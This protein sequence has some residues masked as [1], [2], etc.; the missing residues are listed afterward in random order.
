MFQR[1][2][3]CA[4]VGVAFALCAG[5]AA[6]VS[7]QAHPDPSAVVQ[8]QQEIS[9][10]LAASWLASGDPRTVAW[11]AWVALRDRRTELIPQMI[12][13][14]KTYGI[15]AKPYV[16]TDGHK[17]MLALLDALIQ[18]G[19]QMR[20]RDAER[21]FPEFPIHSLLLLSHSSD[22]ATFSLL[23]I[24][25]HNSEAPV[26]WAA[27]GNLLYQRQS[28]EFVAD[29]W[30]GLTVH[31]SLSVHGKEWGGFPGTGSAGSCGSGIS[32]P[33][34]EIWPEIGTYAATGFGGNGEIVLAA[35]PD[36]VYYDRVV[37]GNYY[38][39][40]FQCGGLATDLDSMR[41]H[42]FAGLLG[43]PPE[44]SS[45]RAHSQSQIL[46]ATDAKYA[47]ELN[48]MVARQE[49]E[50][51]DTAKKLVKRNLLTDSLDV[52][53]APKIE[54]EIIDQ[55]ENSSKSI[56]IPPDLPLNVKAEVVQ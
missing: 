44:D 20:A 26:V 21:L 23:S 25:E 45:I 47:E 43:L 50:L 32:P 39:G 28:P 36:P 9:S 5:A 7:A 48:A 14:T 16:A 17:T 56:F 27:A 10:K 49:A 8:S 3:H 46:W 6:V 37:G 53:H 19:V 34:R 18:L 42:Y 55:R 30:A 4:F 51:E 13:L 15:G 1:R 11:G 41:E 31:I 2:V 52:Y 24:F 22:D 35:G 12:A 33:A 40:P 38:R 29:I 54:I